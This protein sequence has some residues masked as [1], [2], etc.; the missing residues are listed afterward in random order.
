LLS[1]GRTEDSLYTGL[2]E[3]KLLNKETDEARSLL[4]KMMFLNGENLEGFAAA[5][6]LLE[7]QG[8]WKEAI[9][10]LNDLRK[11]VPW[12]LSNL[13]R[14]AEDELHSGRNDVAAKLAAQVIA[15]VS[16]TASDRSASAVVYAKA[17]SST[18]GPSELAAI[19]KSIRT[20]ELPDFGPYAHSIRSTLLM[21]KRDLPS[22]TMRAEL[23]L[24][25]ED[26]SLKVPLFSALIRE[27]KCAQ[28]LDTLDPDKR[29]FGSYIPQSSAPE[30]DDSDSYIQDF[31]YPVER[32]RLSDTET[33]RTAIQMADCAR[34]QQDIDGEIFFRRM[35]AAHTSL[36]QEKQSLLADIEK[37]EQQRADSRE[38]EAQNYRIALNAGRN[39]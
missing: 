28:A 19:Q 2:A 27:K 7:K 38:E 18:I 21:L 9:L 25:P 32:L 36:T 30:S 13:A 17:G 3:V 39:S 10:I 20:N 1:T 22:Q 8:E 37:L 12:D 6:E 26:L 16:A 23:F 11:R 4:R 35:A 5:A 29:R 15:D 24:Y 33:A 14:L 31:N 34:D